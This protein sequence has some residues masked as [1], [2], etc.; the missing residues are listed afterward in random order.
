MLLSQIISAQDKCKSDPTEEEI[1]QS[2]NGRSGCGYCNFENYIGGGGGGGGRHGNRFGCCRNRWDFMDLIRRTFRYKRRCFIRCW[3]RFLRSCF[4]GGCDYCALKRCLC[5]CWSWFDRRKPRCCRR[6]RDRD[7]FS[8]KNIEA[9]EGDM[10]E[11]GGD[12]G[13]AIAGGDMMDM[14]GDGGMAIAGGDM[15]QMEGSKDMAMAS[16]FRG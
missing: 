6:F 9:M 7:D 15:M 14:E 5:G 3:R 12:G 13:M 2:C 10:M 8:N 11:N 16:G 1:E 4:W